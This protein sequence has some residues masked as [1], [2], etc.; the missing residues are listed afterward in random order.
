MIITLSMIRYKGFRNKYWGFTMMQRSHPYVRNIPGLGFYKVLGTGA[1]NGFRPDPDFSAYGFLG[2]WDEESHA[3][4]FFDNSELFNKY[5]ERSDK[6][7]TIYMKCLRVHG[8]WDGKEPFIPAD[9]PPKGDRIA[10]ITRATIAPR[11]LLKFWRKVP[12]VSA[13][14]KTQEGLIFSAGIGEWPLTQMATF[15][16]WENEGYMNAYAYQN[17]KHIEAIR[18]TRTLNWYTEEM[19]ARFRPYRMEEGGGNGER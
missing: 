19:F 13:P 5:R 17:P 2:T 11:R 3:E 6:I 14:L 18:L 16:L 10:V 8:T 1:G 4:D 9:P 15:S 12:S 7:S